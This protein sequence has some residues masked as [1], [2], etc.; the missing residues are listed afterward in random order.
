MLMVVK[1]EAGGAGGHVC[2]EVT[3]R[4]ISSKY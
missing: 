2:C 1:V 3:R 4:G